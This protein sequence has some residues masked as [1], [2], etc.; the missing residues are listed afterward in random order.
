MAETK[1]RFIKINPGFNE[2]NI[3]LNVIFS[4]TLPSEV[5][6]MEVEPICVNCQKWLRRQVKII[7]AK[8][9]YCVGCFASTSP[10]C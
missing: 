5:C 4:N 9:H 7:T 6:L 10:E 2:K 1:P 3:A 8:H